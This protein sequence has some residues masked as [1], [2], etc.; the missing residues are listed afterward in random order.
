[1]DGKNVL[2]TG[3]N[4]HVGYALTKLLVERGYNVRASVRNKNDQEKTL[5]LSKLDID[6]VELDLME[7]KTIDSA[8]DGIDGLFQ[9]AAVYK[10]WAKN[11]EEEIINPSIIG[12]INAL[13]SANRAG[14]RKVV[15]TSSTAAIG[16]SGP[17]GRA[18]TGD[19]WNYESKHPYSYAKTEAEKRAWDFVKNKEM[20]LVVV[21][22][23]AVIGPYFHRHTPSTIMFDK[24]LKG[25][26]KML[27][28]Q[29]FGYVD[30]RDVA[31]GHLKAYENKH[32]EGR[33][34]LCTACLDGFGLMKIIRELEPELKLPEKI[35]PMWKI[36]L[37]ARWEVTKAIFGYTP[38]ISPETVNEYMNKITN[39]DS[40]KAKDVLGWNPIEIQDSIRDTLNWIKQNYS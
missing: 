34:I 30:V 32:A 38:K 36:K 31:L 22:P 27:P 13:E 8:M 28:P 11:P 35:A 20:K 9:V 15:F 26:L 1:M 7:P 23:T 19:N 25:E 24:I 39:Y 2:V 3:A 16:R 29:T 6:L 37:F 10:S 5:P 18:L 40:S 14:V 21:N 17:E 33:H 4:G 12:G